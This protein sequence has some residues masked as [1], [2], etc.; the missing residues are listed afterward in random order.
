MPQIHQL[1]R[2]LLAQAA[3]HF[4]VPPHL[5]AMGQRQAADH[6]QQ[7]G[8]AGAVGAAHAQHRARIERRADAGKKR[9]SA[10]HAFEIV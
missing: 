5:A 9:D 10:A 4:A 3:D 8:L 1:P 7:A 2:V 6:A